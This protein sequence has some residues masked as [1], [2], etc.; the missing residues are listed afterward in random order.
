MRS[1]RPRRV[2]QCACVKSRSVFTLITITTVMDA[3][4]RL[5]V[6]LTNFYVVYNQLRLSPEHP[7][8]QVMMGVIHNLVDEVLQP[9]PQYNPDVAETLED[10]F[11]L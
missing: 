11:F 4:N 6:I 2:Y 1:G 8:V 3:V 10:N 7:F 9:V 5:Q